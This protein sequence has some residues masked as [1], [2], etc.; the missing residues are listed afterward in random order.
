VSRSGK[1]LSTNIVVPCTFLDKNKAASPQNLPP[2][3]KVFVEI[4]LKSDPIGAK[5][6]NI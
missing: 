6:H 5:H 3:R 4:Y 1:H 2:C